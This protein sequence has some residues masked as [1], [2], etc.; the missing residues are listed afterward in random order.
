MMM[1]T[2]AGF[3][4]LFAQRHSSLYAYGY[5]AVV[6]EPFVLRPPTT[7]QGVAGDD[8]DGDFLLGST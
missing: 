2:Q 1:S 7:H 6:P 5:S 4:I 3:Q 8:G